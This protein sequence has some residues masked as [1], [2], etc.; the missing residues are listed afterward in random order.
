MRR[1]LSK[2]SQGADGDG[3]GWTWCY[4][5]KFFLRFLFWFKCGSCLRKYTFNF[6][7]FGE[8]G[9]R[10]NIF[11]MRHDIGYGITGR[12]CLC[13][14]CAKTHHFCIKICNIIPGETA[15]RRCAFGAAWTPS[16]PR[17][18]NWPPHFFR[19]GDVSEYINSSTGL[20]L[21]ATHWCRC[22]EGPPKY[23]AWQNITM[24]DLWS[25][26]LWRAFVHMVLWL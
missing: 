9:E 12:L 6:S 26:C 2:I 14:K 22:W 19:P 18:L 17:H 3:G 24:D 23:A 21:D 25:F 4:T 7:F 11:L 8:E 10:V 1:T 5:Q 20:L 15:P 16:A 13:Q